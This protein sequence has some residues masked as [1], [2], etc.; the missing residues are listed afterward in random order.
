MIAI[1]SVLLP[2]AFICICGL[3]YLFKRADK[4]DKKRLL[5][6]KKQLLDE[7]QLFFQGIPKYFIF[8]EKFELLILKDIKRKTMYCEIINWAEYNDSFDFSFGETRQVIYQ[9]KEQCSCDYILFEDMDE[10][11]LYIIVKSIS[12][13]LNRI[14]KRYI[15]LCE[16]YDELCK[17][18]DGNVND[19]YKENQEDKIYVDDL[20]K[21]IMVIDDEEFRDAINKISDIVKEMNRKIVDNSNLKDSISINTLIYYHDELLRLLKKVEQIKNSNHKT[22]YLE[23]SIK[24]VKEI[25]KNLVLFYEKELNKLYD[26]EVMDIKATGKVLKHMLD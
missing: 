2:T 7:Y 18:Y 13:D 6:E 25:A 8:N 9:I 5:D 3:L 19:S 22:E 10:H 1:A 20:K 21:F 23:V 16:T 24:D 15:E 14:Y 12:N 26:I 11:D 17:T 4:L